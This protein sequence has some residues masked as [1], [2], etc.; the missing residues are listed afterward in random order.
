MQKI[1]VFPG[2]FDPVT[3]GHESVVRRAIPLFDTI[4]VA[5]GVNAEKKSM[6]TTEQRM[7]W[8]RKTFQ[9]C[10]AVQVQAYEGLTV[11]FCRQCSATYILR[12]L[13]SS[14]DFEFERTIAHL[15]QKMVA[16]VETVFL[17]AEQEFSALNSSMVR[18]IIRYG[19]DVSP[20]VP[21]AVAEGV[22]SII[23]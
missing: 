23:K 1:A 7:E 6:F 11:E 20:F 4:I 9:D 12:G 5:L 17:L 22:K 15:N 14:A 10:P 8:L 18:E 19:G 21:A 2:S 13:R 16:E 3:R